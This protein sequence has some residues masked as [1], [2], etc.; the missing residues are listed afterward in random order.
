MNES[1]NIKGVAWK[2]GDITGVNDDPGCSLDDGKV[3]LANFKNLGRLDPVSRSIS[4][5]LARL[6]EDAGLYPSK[7]K[8]DIPLLISS[9]SGFSHSDIDYFQDFV[10][11]KETAGRANLFVYTL[12][13]SPLADASV[14]FGLTGGIAYIEASARSA[15]NA[16]V[17]N[18]E[19]QTTAARV[20]GVA[21][22]DFY[23]IVVAE[24]YDGGADA[25]AVLLSTT[26]SCDTK[27]KFGVCTTLGD[28]ATIAELKQLI[29]RHE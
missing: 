8:L 14:Y 18:V 7:S 19:D 21:L 1:M 5:A 9:D 15:W 27:R 12:P 4:T 17:E 2:I 25:L 10:K 16:L 13:T 28:Y 20:K 6:L 23:I 24:E 26:S 29:F 3:F 11:Y 22:R